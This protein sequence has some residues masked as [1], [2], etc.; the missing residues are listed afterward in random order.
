M[1]FFGKIQSMNLYNIENVY[2]SEILF[3]INNF[4]KNDQICKDC[5]VPSYVMGNNGCIDA[6]PINLPFIE[7]SKDVNSIVK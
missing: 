5:Y 3:P 6:K 4:V 1:I 2:K 7:N